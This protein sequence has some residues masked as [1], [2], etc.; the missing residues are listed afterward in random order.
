VLGLWVHQLPWV[1]AAV[2]VGGMVLPMGAVGVAL[3]RPSARRWFDLYCPKCQ[4][5]SS[6]G[7]DFLFR[8]ARCPR[9]G[10]VW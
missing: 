4:T 6:R 3:G 2:M 10:A 7:K 9:C 1:Q 5:P 8:Q